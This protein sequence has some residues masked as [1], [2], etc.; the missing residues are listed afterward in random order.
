MNQ[1]LQ[2]NGRPLR[3]MQMAFSHDD[4]IR[5]LQKKNKRC[6]T[7]AQCMAHFEQDYYWGGHVFTPTLRALGYETFLCLPG[8]LHSQALWCAE[9]K[10][11][12]LPRAA[13]NHAMALYQVAVFQPDVLYVSHP[14]FYDDVFLEALPMAPSVILG[15][16]AAATAADISWKLFDAILSSHEISMLRAKDCGARETIFALPG[17]PLELATELK[18]QPRRTDVSFT[19]YWTPFHKYRN[20][21]LKDL[22]AHAKPQSPKDPQSLRNPLDVA[23]YLPFFNGADP[24]PEAVSACNRGPLWGKSMFRAMAASR[25][26]LNAHAE[27]DFGFQNLS[28]NMRQMEAT[29]SGSLLLT[30]QSPNLEAFFTPGEHLVTFT[31]SAS[32]LAAIEHYLAHPEEGQAI[33]ARGQAHCLHHYNMENRAIAFMDTVARIMERKSGR[34]VPFAALLRGL[35]A[36]LSEGHV[37]PDHADLLHVVLDRAVHGSD[38]ERHAAGEILAGVDL[39]TTLH[40]CLFRAKEAADRSDTATARALLHQELEAFPYNDIARHALSLLILNQCPQSEVQP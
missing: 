29:G 25:L 1:P 16:S 11:G 9:H 35:G 23:Y 7:H 24:I 3:V 30:Q 12:D 33:A 8:D 20:Q 34:M 10:V 26:T 28:P 17:Y 15:W 19:G 2:K 21:L 36:V 39:S 14:H 6:T 40:G 37:P 27:L 38:A 22:A 31:D 32:M 5:I 13:L 18:S 4:Y